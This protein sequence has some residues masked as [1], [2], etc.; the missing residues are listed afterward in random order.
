LIEVLAF[1]DY[2]LGGEA[3]FQ[4]VLRRFGFSVD[5]NG[6]FGFRTVDA[7]RF[8]SGLRHETT[9]PSGARVAGGRTRIAANFWEVVE[10][11]GDL[12]YL[13]M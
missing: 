11:M 8:R 12:G 6:A 4:G 1:D 3:V 10:R 13:G 7:S 5:A 2:A 9:S